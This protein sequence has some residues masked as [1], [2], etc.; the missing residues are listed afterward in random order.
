MSCLLCV[1]LLSLRSAQPLYAG[2][3]KNKHPIPNG[4]VKQVIIDLNKAD[5]KIRPV[6]QL[7]SMMDGTRG[8]PVINN[9][10]DWEA[11]VI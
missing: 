5:A 2:L 11:D 3:D 8:R 7:I 4:G 6:E 10:W 1:K 9:E